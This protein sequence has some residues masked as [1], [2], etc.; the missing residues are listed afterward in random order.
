MR[1]TPSASAGWMQYTAFMAIFLLA[2]LLGTQVQKQWSALSFFVFYAALFG[3]VYLLNYFLGKFNCK[4]S[5]GP[6]GYQIKSLHK[7]F[8]RNQIPKYFAWEDMRHYYIEITPKGV[9]RLH[10]FTNSG[11]E[12]AFENVN[13]RRF[14]NYLKLNF[15]EKNSGDGKRM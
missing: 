7:R 8:S 3:G 10:L 1:Q 6:D 4:V 9:C 11:E 12:T 13:M 5:T 2:G 15:P 14:Y